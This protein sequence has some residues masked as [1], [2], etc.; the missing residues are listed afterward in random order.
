MKQTGV[1]ATLVVLSIIIFLLF[2]VILSI[3]IV[4]YQ[5]F[6]IADGTA[7]CEEFLN[8][9]VLQFDYDNG[10]GQPVTKTSVLGYQEIQRDGVFNVKVAYRVGSD[11]SLQ[12]YFIIGSPYHV[13]LGTKNM[14]IIYSVLTVFSLLIVLSFIPM[15]SLK[16]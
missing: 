6:K 11:Q 8:R 13:F 7:I 10:T 1:R 12:E 2:L 15:R 5:H 4:Q 14:V 9:C 3:S 16:K